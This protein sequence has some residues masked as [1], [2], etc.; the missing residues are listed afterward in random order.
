MDY[1]S[2]ECV[3][4]AVDFDQHTEIRPEVYD[5]PVYQD[6]RGFVYCVRD[7]LFSDMIQ[8]TYI[9]ENHSRGLVRAWH[10]H[11]KGDTY[12]HVLS[13]VVKLAAM[14]ID[15]EEDV[16]C[17]VLTDRKPQLFYVPAG[18]Y[19]GAVSLTDNTK[20]LVYSTLTFDQV[21]SDDQRLDWKVNKK[22]WEVK[23]R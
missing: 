23:N 17:A 8:R 13:G 19:N 10:G 22:I 14:N 9:V 15:N 2:T 16:T 7:H 20:I 6:D 4:E 3:P 18:F 11:R 1:P 5:I 12:M 21:K